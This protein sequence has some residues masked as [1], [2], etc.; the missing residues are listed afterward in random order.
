MELRNRKDTPEN[1]EH[2]AEDMNLLRYNID[3]I[4]NHGELF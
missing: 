1:A 4:H 2:S 3:C